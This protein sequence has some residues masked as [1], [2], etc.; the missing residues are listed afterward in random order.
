MNHDR[1]FSLPMMRSAWLEPVHLSSPAPWAGHIPF[2]AWLMA[3]MRP[4]TL[5]ELGVYSGISYLAFAQAAVAHEV[6][7]RMWG[8][9][10]WQGDEHA[11]HY[12]GARILHTLRDKHDAPYGGFSTLLQKTFDEALADIADGSVDVLHIDGLHTYDAVRHDF[13]TWRVK[14]SARG[15]VLFHDIAVRAGDFGV[16]RYWEE[17]AQQYPAFAFTHS[18]GLG[19]L[20]VGDDVPEVLRTLAQGGQYGA[21]VQAYFRILGERFEHRAL[22]MHRDTEI[23][24]WQ[25]K[26]AAQ[27]RWIE[28]QDAQLREQAVQLSDKE[29]KIQALQKNFDDVH[30]QLRQAEAQLQAADKKERDWRAQ[31]QAA[32]KKERDWQAQVQQAEHDVHQLLQSRSWRLTAPLRTGGV[33]ARRMR[34]LAGRDIP[35]FVR[36]VRKALGYV[37]T[38]NWRE[39]KQRIRHVQHQAAHMQ[40][41]PRF[42][43]QDGIRAGILATPH[44]RFVAEIIAAALQRAGVSAQIVAESREYPLDVY[45]VVCPQMFK[46]LPA[47]EKRIAFQMEQ[48][49][50]SRWFTEEYLEVLENSLAVLDY[51]R[52]NIKKLRDYG[53]VFPHVF[54][55][56]IG[57]AQTYAHW[58]DIHADETCDVLFYG[59]A[60]AP[61][62][63]RLLDVVAQHFKVRVLGNTFGE[64]MYRALAGAKVVVNIHYYEGALLETTRLYECLSLGKSIV[65]EA[66]ADQAEHAEMDG[67]VRFVPVDDAQALID[68]LREALAEQESEEGRAAYAARCAALVASSQARFQFFLYR[69]LLSQRMI[70]FARFAELTLPHQK[71]APR[72]AL[73]LP[74]VVERRDAFEAVRPADVALFDGVRYTPG[75]LGAA[76]SYKFLA[77]CALAQGLP[78]LEIMEDDV[79]FPADYAERREKVEAWLAAHDGQWDAFVGMMA[80]VHPDTRVLDVSRVDGETFVTIDRMISMVG[81]IYTPDAL[82]RLARWDEHNH[83]ADTNT[84]DRFL[85]L[86]GEMRVV[87]TLPFLLGHCEEMD[88]SLWGFS[89]VRYAQMIAKAQQELEKRVAEF[90]AQQG[91]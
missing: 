52:V 47:G 14:L 46:H 39:L 13:E 27:H 22:H 18:N 41:L 28:G 78:R 86:Q 77:Q 79:E 82:A 72:M 57:G 61:R 55:A 87:V 15:V 10:T 53:I 35:T 67:V 88:S 9:D 24:D 76:M 65:S 91:A 50:S 3:V 83:D 81:N 32:E 74:E 8:V 16:W 68:A 1:D 80:L 34:A 37:L 23:A 85:Q 31:L 48:S 56:P 11:G 2:A 71:I 40:R 63:K 70:D 64:D 51:S 43:G 12:D 73:A 33:C 66:A 44:T 59:D 29:L 6:P 45:F 89:N 20:L 26:A 30:A 42:D 7:V 62:R 4:D 25:E 49:V 75:W 36:R 84:I 69:L 19:V 90:D 5:V 58:Q 60:N 21:Q 17:L 38:G 54:Y